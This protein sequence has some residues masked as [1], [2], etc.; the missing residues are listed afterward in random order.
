MLI[1]VF[2]YGDFTDGMGQEHGDCPNGRNSKHSGRDLF[3]VVLVLFVC[4]QMFFPGIIAAVD[5]RILESDGLEL[6]SA[7]FTGINILDFFIA[8]LISI[9]LDA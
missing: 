9:E 7:A 2:L 3:L 1:V 8:I 5:I 4:L 6:V